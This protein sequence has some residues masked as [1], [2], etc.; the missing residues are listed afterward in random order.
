MRRC[1]LRGGIFDVE[2]GGLV[3]ARSGGLVNSFMESRVDIEVTTNRKLSTQVDSV[4]FSQEL[5]RGAGCAV[6]VESC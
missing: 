5:S 4:W 1:Y 2:S 6:F 3:F